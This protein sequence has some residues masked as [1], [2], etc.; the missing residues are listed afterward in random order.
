VGTGVGE[1]DGEADG[2]GVGEGVAVGSGVGDAVG[3]AVGV[4]VSEGVG[5]GLTVGVWSLDPRQPDSTS[6]NAAKVR[7]TVICR[8]I[9]A[10]IYAPIASL[11]FDRPAVV[12]PMLCPLYWKPYTPPKGV[13]WRPSRCASQSWPPAPVEPARQGLKP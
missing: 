9:V 12:A 7:R 5:D 4:G 1:G 11:V 8:V 13:L 3:A 2:V 6:S 10:V